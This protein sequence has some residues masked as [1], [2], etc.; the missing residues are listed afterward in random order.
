MLDESLHAAG[1]SSAQS[2]E[3]FH[4]S[5][6]AECTR[7]SIQVSGEELSALSQPPA[8]DRATAKIGRLRLGDCARKDCSGCYYRFFFQPR[9]EVDWEKLLHEVDA[10]S[11][12]C[13]NSKQERP[14][15]KWHFSVLLHSKHFPRIG[16]AVAG[17]I[18]LLTVRQWRQGGQI[19]FLREA[20]HFRVDTVQ[21]NHAP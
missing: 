15:P 17:I 5:V 11:A 6:S 18:V 10:L 19:P 2:V 12:P 1:L 8:A 20:E 13:S 9:A 4:S 7:C 16:M 3:I 21:D 14:L